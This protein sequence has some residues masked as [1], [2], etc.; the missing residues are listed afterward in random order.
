MAGAGGAALLQ[1]DRGAAV[2]DG[3]PRQGFDDNRETCLLFPRAARARGGRAVRRGGLQPAARHQHVLVGPARGAPALAGGETRSARVLRAGRR[4]PR[5][6]A[7]PSAVRLRAAPGARACRRTRRAD[8]SSW[9]RGLRE[10]TNAHSRGRSARRARRRAVRASTRCC[11]R[12][13]PAPATTCVAVGHAHIDTAWLWPIAETRRK[14]L[15]SW[16]NVLELMERF[17]ELP[18]RRQPGPAVRL[19]RGGLAGAVRA[20]PARAS[21]RGAGRPA[22]PCG[23]SPTPTARRASRWSARSSTARVT[24]GRSSA[25][26]AP[27]PPLPARHLRLPGVAAADRAARRTRHLHHRQDGV[28]ASATRSRTSPSAGAASTAPRCWPTSR[29]APTTTRRSSPRTCGGARERSSPRTTSD[30]AEP[31]FLGRWLQ[32]FGYGDGGGGPT[33]E[34]VVRAPSSP[35]TCE[36]LPA[37]RAGADRRVLRAAARRARRTAARRSG[38]DLP[39]WDGELYLEQHRGT[40]TSQ[41]WLKPANAPRREPPAAIEALLVAAARRRTSRR[42]IAAP[43]STPPGRR[44]SSTSSTTSSPAPRSPRSTPTRAPRTRRLEQELER[45]LDSGRRAAGPRRAPAGAPA[46]RSWCSTP[47]RTRAPRW[48]GMGDELAAT[49]RD[50]PPL[51]GRVVVG[52]RHS[53]ALPFRVKVTERTLDNELLAVTVDE[54]GR[55]RRAQAQRTRRRGQRGPADGRLHPSNQLV[56]YEDRP[57]RWEAWNIDQDYTDKADAPSTAPPIRSRSS[58]AGTAPR[59]RSRCGVA[60]GESAIVSATCWPRASGG[61]EVETHDRLAGGAHAASGRSTRSTSARGTGPAGSS[62]ATSSGRPTATRPGTRRASRC[63]VTAGWTSPSRGSAWPCWTTASSGAP[64]H[65]NVLGLTLLRSPNFPDPDADR[66]EHEF[67]YG[68]PAP[69]RRL[70]RRRCAARGGRAW[71]SRRSSVGAVRRGRPT[72]PHAT[73]AAR[74]STFRLSVEETGTS[75]S[76]RSSRRRTAR[77]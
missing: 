59:R 35:P 41:A 8:P 5:P 65:G 14:I 68:A 40:L 57:R 58:R 42:T 21:P 38:R 50:L 13:R 60:S 3:A 6:A 27:A 37:R 16:S 69:R 19:L 12:R 55:D 47:A 52:R 46:S 49:S 20:H 67:R 73:A 36:G 54:A 61:L 77:A 74:R 56:A 44:C 18:L 9:S 34:T 71:P 30:R 76:R 51:G 32:P 31:A 43:S 7:L 28:V 63:P 26:P 48:S 66:G 62:S 29:R 33:E 22:A 64:C 15:R 53:A 17:P 45:L 2:V 10:I 70:A 1:R 24:G 25:T 23:S 4:R 11:R 75:R 39:V 72:G